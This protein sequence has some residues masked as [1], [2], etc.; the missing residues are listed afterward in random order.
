MEQRI[1]DAAPT[2]MF[3]DEGVI[4][5]AAAL[6]AQRARQGTEMDQSDKL[7]QRRPRHAALKRIG[8][9]GEP[10]P[11][12]IGGF[13]AFGVPVMKPIT[14]KKYPPPGPVAGPRGGR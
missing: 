5:I 4:D 2:V 3:R 7:A 14:G 9:I 11:Y 13:L 8:V 6:S 1:G 12:D 10:S